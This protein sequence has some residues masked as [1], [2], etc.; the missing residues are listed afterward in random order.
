MTIAGVRTA[1]LAL[2]L[3][4]TVSAARAQEPTATAA[5]TVRD[6]AG[7]PVAGAQVVVQP[8]GLET[9]TDSAGHFSL[10]APVGRYVLRV[11][12]PA[13][14]PYSIA[15]DLTGPLATLEVVLRLVPRFTEDVVVAAVRADV[16]TPVT[17]RTIPRTEI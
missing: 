8:L 10:T 9:V 14:V 13:C 15:L 7:T 5:G 17:K 2:A 4:V 6:T 16:E 12:H 1:G 11:V 3:A